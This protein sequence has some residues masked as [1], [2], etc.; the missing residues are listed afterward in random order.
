MIGQI[1]ELEKEHG[2]RLYVILKHALISTNPSDLAAQMQQE[3]LPDGGGMVIVYESDT[4]RMGFGRGLDSREGLIENESGVPAYKVVEIVTSSLEASAG[5][6]AAE[7]YLQKVV[8]EICSNLNEYFER[9]QAPV[10]GGRSLRLGLVTIGALSLLALCGMGLGWL[11]GKA[12][13]RQSQKRVFPVIEVPERLSA[14]YGGSCG[15]T[16]YFGPQTK[17]MK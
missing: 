11:M 9:K 7:P 17:E 15:G 13:K 4:K 5:I 2:Y 6:E 12:D 8:T 3:W 16:G 1:H 14:P 10:E